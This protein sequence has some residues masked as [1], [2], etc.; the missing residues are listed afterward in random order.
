MV[1]DSPGLV[2]RSWYVESKIPRGDKQEIELEFLQLLKIV[3]SHFGRT[4]GIHF[5]IKGIFP[6]SLIKESFLLLKHHP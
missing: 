3:F 5:P 6:D 4:I 2:P 1:N